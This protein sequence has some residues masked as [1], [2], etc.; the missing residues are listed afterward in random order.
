M[1][2]ENGGIINNGLAFA[3]GVD[4]AIWSFSI[5]NSGLNGLLKVTAAGTPNAI[6]LTV[7]NTRKQKMRYDLELCAG[8]HLVERRGYR[9]QESRH[10][11]RRI[12][13][14]RPDGHCPTICHRG[15][16][17]PARQRNLEHRT[18]LVEGQRPQ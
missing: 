18:A 17:P 1:E 10:R 2:V 16:D 14:H 6:A 13:Q 9:R 5:N 3:P 12:S 4:T 7:A 11:H 8:R 15:S